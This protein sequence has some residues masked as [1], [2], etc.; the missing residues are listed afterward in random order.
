MRLVTPSLTIAENDGFN[1][2]IFERKFFAV[3]LTNIIKNSNDPLVIGLDGNWGEGKT[4]F[5]K[6]WQQHLT[7]EQIPNIYIDAF[8]NDHTD[9]AFMVVASAITDYAKINATPEK[10]KELI[11]KTKKV[12]AQLITWGA[13][14]SI[15][16]LTL[17][18]IKETDI[19]D[20][21]RIG[22][23]ISEGFS[24]AAE[25]L[26]EEKLNN[27]KQ[28]IESIESFKA[29]LSTLPKNLN[30]TAEKPTLT[31]IIDELDRCRPSFAIEILEKIKHLFSV[32]N[33][34]FIL[35]INKKQIEESIR[36]TYGANIDAHTYLQKFINIETRLPKRTN[37][38]NNDISIYCEKLQE[39][40]GISFNGNRDLTKTM[41]ALGNHFQL[42]LRQLEKSYSN[43]VLT[44]MAF[45]NPANT[46][47]ALVSFFSIL[48]VIN[49]DLF[50]KISK[51]NASLDEIQ[52]LFA[53]IKQQH[54]SVYITS[55]L[56]LLNFCFMSNDDYNKLSQNDRTRRFEQGFNVERRKDV[57]TSYITPLLHFTFS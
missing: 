33:I 15:K 19:D 1:Q 38:Y 44:Y 5:V 46:Y 26:I 35:V 49:P 34:T 48:K 52:N 43:V 30:P 20:L 4:T 56:E 13:K 55:T 28:D 50:I 7:S 32:E 29:F 42:S 2:D 18:I 10:T 25:K 45:S 51:D 16:A 9:D 22:D 8:S 6:M 47:I 57:A 12:G 23:D 17:G 11:Y 37:E 31:V 40:H 41:A 54:N 21:S 36:S 39:L 24:S 3:A 53:D 27:H 14:V